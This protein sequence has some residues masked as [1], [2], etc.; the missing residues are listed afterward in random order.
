MLTRSDGAG[1]VLDWRS[2]FSLGGGCSAMRLK[3]RTALVTGGSR[4][5]GRAIALALGEEGADVAVNYV[6]SEG[7]ARDVVGNIK[8]MG[9]GAILP[10]ADVG[11]IP[12][13]FPL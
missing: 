1:T 5:I 4:G 11:D 13:P 7:P 10:Q 2:A 6:S 9:R 3:G 8:K 12:Q